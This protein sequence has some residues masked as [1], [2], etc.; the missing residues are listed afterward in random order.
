MW[1]SSVLCLGSLKAAIGALA[2]LHSHREAWL[3]KN[4][5][6]NSLGCSQS[7]LFVAVE[8]MVAHF[9]KTRR[10]IFPHESPSL[11]LKGFHLTESGPPMIISLWIHLNSTDLKIHSL[12]LYK[13]TWSRK[14]QVTFYWLKQ[15]HRFFSHSKWENC[16][17]VWLVW[18][19]FRVCL[20]V[21]IIKI[22]W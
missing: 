2:E 13:V 9:F 21:L 11:S 8:L 3:R 15:N 16:K 18:G 1:L 22:M 10:R 12:L 4:L 14:W 7:L 17:S 19:H 20:P 5:L 6:L